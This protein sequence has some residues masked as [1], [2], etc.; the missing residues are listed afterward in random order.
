MFSEG[1]THF[2]T[3]WHA[4]MSLTDLGCSLFNHHTTSKH[5]L[6]TYQTWKVFYAKQPTP[7]KKSLRINENSIVPITYYS[8][9]KSI[10]QY[11]RTSSPFSVQDCPSNLLVII[12][13]NCLQ[14]E[15]A[16]QQNW[17]PHFCMFLYVLRMM[18]FTHIICSLCELFLS[19][20]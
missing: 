14:Y 13:C 2:S 4:K 11:S 19:G 5:A 1:Q 20:N 18:L 10:S 17:V 9:I 3:S 8:M 6:K 16:K 12:S 7:D 15:D